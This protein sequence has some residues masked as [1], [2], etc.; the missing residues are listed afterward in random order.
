MLVLLFGDDLL[1]S[2]SGRK[3]RRCL[4]S[5]E[6]LDHIAFWGR[7]LGILTIVALISLG[8]A[9]VQYT[10]GQFWDLSKVSITPISPVIRPHLELPVGRRVFPADPPDNVTTRR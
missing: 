1:V 4:L 10:Q 5:V 8:R 2:T 3:F 7:F 9:K 6:E